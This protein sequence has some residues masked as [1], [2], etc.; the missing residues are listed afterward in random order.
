MPHLVPAYNCTNNAATGY[1]S[2][3]ILY[4]REPRL[5]IDVEFG[6]QKDNYKMPHINLGKAISILI[7]EQNTCYVNSRKGIRHCMIIGAAELS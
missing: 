3:F 1:S 5:P 6:L 4:G 7:G 2:Y